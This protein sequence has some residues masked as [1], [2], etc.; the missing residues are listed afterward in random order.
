MFSSRTLILNFKKSLF[1]KE[2]RN[3][4]NGLTTLKCSSIVIL[5]FL[6]S[7]ALGSLSVQDITSFFSRCRSNYP[8]HKLKGFCWGEHSKGQNESR[9]FRCLGH[10]TGSMWEI[11]TSVLTKI[12]SL[13][14]CNN[15]L[16]STQ[17]INT[18]LGKCHM[19]YPSSMIY[20]CFDLV[21]GKWAG[22]LKISDFEC[23][24]YY[25]WEPG[26]QTLYPGEGC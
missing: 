5:C 22:R 13:D 6:C 1:V 9:I 23:C 4:F 7:L 25:I 14:H 17:L 15:S 26:R 19:K 18:D 24:S 16:T 11:Q 3:I 12:S 20:I 10:P 8:G 21:V 2:R